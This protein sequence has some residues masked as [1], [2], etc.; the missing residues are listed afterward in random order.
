M[1]TIKYTKHALLFVCMTGGLLTAGHALADETVNNCA[2]IMS[3]NEN[4][5]NSTPGNKGSTAAIA[6]AVDAES[7]END[8]DCA[9]LTVQSIY[10]WGDAPDFYGTTASASGAVHEIY[11]GLHL[12]VALD[13]ETDGQ[14]ST[15]ALGDDQNGDDED[16]VITELN[17]TDG[18]ALTL[19]LTASN[20]SSTDANVMCWIDYDGNGIFATDGSESGSA[21]IPAGSADAAISVSMPMPVVPAHAST[22][23]GGSSYM[24]CRMTTATMDASNATGSLPDGEVEDYAVSFTPVPVFDLA[25]RKSLASDQSA[26]VN[27]GDTVNYVIEVFNQGNIEASNVAIMD[28]IPAD[29]QLADSNWTLNGTQAS[30]NTPIAAIPAGGFA[31]VTIALKV[32]ANAPVGVLRNAAEIVSANG[33]GGSPA[34]D[35]DSS[36]DSDSANDVFVDDV[37]DN[38]SSDEDDHDIADVTVQ[39]SA[40]V[41]MEK[42]VDKL[43]VNRG[44]TFDYTLTV[45]NDGPHAA[46][47]V[48]VNDPLPIHAVDYLNDDSSDAYDP[49]TGNWSVGSLAVGES[50]VINITV[51]V[52]ARSIAAP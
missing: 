48:V 31:T 52:K 26:T 24:R 27:V 10:D 29:M 9:V 16:G 39:A 19:S 45:T 18:Q 13:D 33:V 38:T 15:D 12:G 22:A 20:A 3:A 25:L 21:L 42:T 6:T 36:F 44:E 11:P 8:E 49:V 2:E 30:L 51:R 40:D 50:K 41:H 7:N 32:N 28:Y 1:K 14:A 17:L 47:G 46:T 5:P 4:D 34:T 35:A 23:T 37:I 43:R